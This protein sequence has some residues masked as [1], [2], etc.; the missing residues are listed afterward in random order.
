[1]SKRNVMA[2]GEEINPDKGQ[3]LKP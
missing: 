3:L 2:E 1:M